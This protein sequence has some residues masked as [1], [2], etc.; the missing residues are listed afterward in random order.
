MPNAISK[1]TS[2]PLFAD[3]SKC[4]QVTLGRYD[5]E[6]LQD[7]LNKL[8]QWS[9]IWGMDFN[10]K[11]CKVLRVDRI[12][13]LDDRDY[14]LGGIKLDRV[15]VEKDLGILL[16]HNL[17]WN[18]HVDVISLKAQK[19]LYV[20][21][22]TCKDINDIRTKKLLYIAWVRPAL[23]MLAWYGHLIPKETSTTWNR[24]STG[25]QDSFL[26]GIILSTSTLVS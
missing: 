16:S 6:K 26:E 8:F 2:L 3:D 20:L 21:Y 18:N 23:N 17:S 15:D 4:F 10:A 11:K 5:G 9:C 12:R 14:Y 24:Y 1:E 13:S 22:R 19:M 25:L 7:D